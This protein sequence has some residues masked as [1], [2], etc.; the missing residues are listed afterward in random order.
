MPGNLTYDSASKE[1]EF[2]DLKNNIEIKCDENL[3]GNLGSTD[4][5]EIDIK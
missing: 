1:F 3:F 4:Y 5:N 2:P